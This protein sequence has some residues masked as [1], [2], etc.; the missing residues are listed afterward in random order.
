MEVHQINRYNRYDKP[1]GKF[2][3]S[4]ARG[5]GPQLGTGQTHY[6]R[7]V[8]G[9]Y[10]D[11]TDCRTPMQFEDQVRTIGGGT[12]SGPKN[13]DDR[14]APRRPYGI[15]CYNCGLVGHT[16]SSCPR[17]QRRNLNG[18]GRTRTTPSSKPK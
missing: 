6:S 5:A 3:W 18:I 7:R 8:D 9:T 2:Q 15:Q 17:G 11:R 4:G 1:R 14:C 12:V 13:D 16:R 10:S